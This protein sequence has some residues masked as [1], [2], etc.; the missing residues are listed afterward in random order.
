MI[1]AYDERGNLPPG[2]HQATWKEL[3]ATFGGSQHREALLVGLRE[4]LLS[5]RRVGCRTAYIDGSFVTT[6]E[7]PAD[8]DACWDPEGVDANALDPLFLDF[9]DW[10]RAQKERFGGELF[11]ANALADAAGT[12]F[13]QYFLRDRETGEPKGI[14][15]IDLEALT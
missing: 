4:A 8:F 14:I 9:L 5:L 15:K 1:P 12:E 2:I 13:L 6:K 11:P 3:E 10:R 7:A